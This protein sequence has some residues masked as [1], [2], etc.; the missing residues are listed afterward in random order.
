MFGAFYRDKLYTQKFIVTCLVLLNITSI[1]SIQ[2]PLHH[3]T[4]RQDFSHGH[5]PAPGYLP[6]CPLLAAPLFNKRIIDKQ[7]SF[8]LGGTGVIIQ[9]YNV[10]HQHFVTGY[11]RPHRLHNHF[12]YT[13]PALLIGKLHITV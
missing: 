3:L 4:K 8:K 2:C 13:Y 1:T 6:F 5:K 9:Q 10:N 12:A 11:T 7:Y